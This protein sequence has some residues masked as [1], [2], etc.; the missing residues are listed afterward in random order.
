VG[1]EAVG[2]IRKLVALAGHSDARGYRQW[3]EV[4]RHVKKGRKSFP[5]LVP[6][7]RKGTRKNAETGEE[8][9]YQYVA[10]FSSAPVFGLSQTEG[11]PLPDTNPEIAAWLENLPLLDVAREWDLSVDA[12][13]ASA[14][15]DDPDRQGRLDHRR[16]HPDG[17]RRHDSVQDQAAR[18]RLSP[19]RASRSGPRQ[20]ALLQKWFSARLSRSRSS[21]LTDTG[22]RWAG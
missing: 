3:Q 4:G 15:L 19:R 14:R 5:I 12:Y 13:N 8:E 10:G 7:M 11:D 2:Q 21:K 16:R 17:S 9:D 18:N 20:N 22:G 1:L 6:V